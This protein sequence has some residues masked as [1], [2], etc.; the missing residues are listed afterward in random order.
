MCARFL[1][2]IIIEQARSL[3]KNNPEDSKMILWYEI[4]DVSCSFCFFL[5]YM[6]ILL[7]KSTAWSGEAGLYLAC[8][9]KEFKLVRK[10]ALLF[11]NLCGPI[12]ALLNLWRLQDDPPLDLS[13]ASDHLR[14]FSDSGFAVLWQNSFWHTV[15]LLYLV[16]NIKKNSKIITIEKRNTWTVYFQYSF[17]SYD[18]LYENHHTSLNGQF[19]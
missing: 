11:E 19:S 8:W 13:Y 17:Q 5:T 12:L 2:I 1:E 3:Y 6:Q 18:Y 15:D 9:P 10:I 7:A 16:G 4:G 14:F